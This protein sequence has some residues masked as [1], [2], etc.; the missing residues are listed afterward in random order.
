LS[1]SARVMMTMNVWRSVDVNVF[2][3]WMRKKR[4]VY[5]GRL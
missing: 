3:W 5:V 1:P 4:S 2:W